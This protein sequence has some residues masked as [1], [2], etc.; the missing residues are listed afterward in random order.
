MEKDNEQV[1]CQCEDLKRLNQTLIRNQYFLLRDF[2]KFVKDS[3]KSD[4]DIL[5][6]L[7]KSSSTL[8]CLLPDLR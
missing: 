7:E 1:E 5:E 6:L 3:I 4:A 8:D 2:R